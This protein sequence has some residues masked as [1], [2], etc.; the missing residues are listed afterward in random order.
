MT[1]ALVVPDDTVG[2]V[3]AVEET[4]PVSL[5]GYMIALRFDCLAWL[6]VDQSSFKMPPVSPESGFQHQNVQLR[7]LA[8]L[9]R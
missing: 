5:S 2:I 7:P 8:P 1:S 9:P 4:V 6:I 3:G